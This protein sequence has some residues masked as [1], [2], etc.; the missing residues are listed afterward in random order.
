MTPLQRIHSRRK[1][2]RKCQHWVQ[3]ESHGCE[4]L[5]KPCEVESRWVMESEDWCSAQL[6]GHQAQPKQD[7]QD[8]DPREDVPAKN[9]KSDHN[10]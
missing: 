2:C 7:N 5:E 1:V 9:P 3:G 6:E 8:D 4:L 10:N